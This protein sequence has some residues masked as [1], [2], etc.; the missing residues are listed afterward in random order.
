MSARANQTPGE[1]PNISIRLNREA[2]RLARIQSVIEEKK[3][4]EWLDEAI[5]EKLARLQGGKHVHQTD[6]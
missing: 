6:R 4:G 1:T 3:L 5:R 2:Y